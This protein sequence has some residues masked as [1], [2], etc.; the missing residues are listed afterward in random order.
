MSASPPAQAMQLCGDAISPMAMCASTP[1][2][3]P[4]V[5]IDVNSTIDRVSP[6]HKSATWNE[7]VS[8]SD[9]ALSALFRQWSRLG[10]I[11]AATLALAETCIH[12]RSICRPN[13]LEYFWPHSRPHLHQSKKDWTRKFSLARFSRLYPL[14]LLTLL[15]VAVIQFVSMKSFGTYQIYGQNDLYH[16]F[17]NLFFV[18]SWGKLGDGFSFNAPTW[19]V[20][21]EIVVYFIF[22]ALLAVL[23]RGKIAV[24]VALLIG[25]W[26]LIKKYPTISE[27]I[28]FFQCLMYFLAGVSIYFAVSFSK[29]IA[30]IATLIALVPI[31][32]FSIPAFRSGYG[33]IALLLICLAAFLDAFPITNYLQRLRIV[34]E[35]TYSVFLWH[36][37]IQMIILMIMMQFNISNSIAQS[38]FFLLFFLVLTYSVGY[39]SYRWIEQPARKY[40]NNRFMPAQ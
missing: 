8:N 24:P 40:I 1:I 33:F 13:F 27:D 12:V 16:F 28:F 11:N 25:M 35:L 30:K 23:R 22:F 2:T 37:P 32:L 21:V 5:E 36:V 10:P 7:L 17:T 34:G 38:P 14:H 3:P 18:Q 26:F 4:K 9:L 15:V 31:I 39:A 19:S 20:S 6:C 29:P